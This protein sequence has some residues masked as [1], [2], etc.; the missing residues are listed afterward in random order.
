MCIV[1]P[2]DCVLHECKR[3]QS[4]QWN[5][6]QCQCHIILRQLQQPQERCR[7]REQEDQSTGR[8]VCQSNR[9]VG[10][11]DSKIGMQKDTPGQT[12][13]HA[14]HSDKCTD[15]GMRCFQV[16]EAIVFL[17]SVNTIQTRKGDDNGIPTEHSMQLECGRHDVSNKENLLVWTVEAHKVS[18]NRAQW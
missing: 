12:Q 3:H 13:R 4:N 7:P 2:S 10:F 18:Q 1:I 14:I 16:I 17:V 11:I 15:S 8:F 6:V 5:S 9:L